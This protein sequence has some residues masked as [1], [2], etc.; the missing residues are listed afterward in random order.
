MIG[1][2]IKRYK[3]GARKLTPGDKHEI[4]KNPEIG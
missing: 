3:L 1:F 2:H 4:R